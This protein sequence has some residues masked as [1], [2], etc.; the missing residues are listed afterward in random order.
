MGDAKKNIPAWLLE[1]R[2]KWKYNGSQRPNFAE[3]PKTGQTSV[4]D[5]P[6]PPALKKEARGLLVQRNGVTIAKTTNALVVKETAS[7]PTYYLPLIDIDSSLLV[8]IPKKSSLCEWKGSAHYFALREAPNKPIAWGYRNP[9]PLFENLV[10]HL[11]F[12]PQHL[13]C[14][15]AGE[16][17]VPQPGTFYAGWITQD[18]AGPFKGEPGSGWW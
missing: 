3:T 2:S 1:S 6:R 14:F 10:D 16:K 9:F 12:Y 18:L 5:Y 8:E 4:W 11:A 13:N 7:P 17:V 15:V